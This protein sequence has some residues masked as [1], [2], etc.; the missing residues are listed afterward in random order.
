MKWIVF[1]D[2]KCGLCLGIV[3]FLAHADDRDHLRFAPLQGKTASDK[4]L[5]AHAD[6]L[7]GSMVVWREVDD[8]TYLRSDAVME[9]ARA[10]GGFWRLIL[11]FR[12]LP[13]CW[14]DSLY[15]TVASNRTRWFGQ[16]NHCSLT[17]EKLRS[18]LL[19]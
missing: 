14:R 10:L 1:F 5:G 7:D 2:G 18:C 11:L 19:P 16:A 3:Q 17:D 4:H 9:V 15:R 13:H 12:I 8:T 6:S